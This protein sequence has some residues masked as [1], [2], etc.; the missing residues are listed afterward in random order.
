MLQQQ[1][2]IAKIILKIIKH[3]FVEDNKIYFYIG[4]LIECDLWKILLMP[5]HIYILF[6]RIPIIYLLSK[7]TNLQYAGIWYAMIISNLI[8]CTIGQIIHHTYPWDNKQI[9]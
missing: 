4:K 9:S 2:K 1:V 8:T 6:I 3:N 5:L 7:Y